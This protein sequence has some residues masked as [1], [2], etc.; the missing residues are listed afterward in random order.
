MTEPLKPR[1]PTPLNAFVGGVVEP[2]LAARGFSQASLIAH[3][4][5]I[6]GE[7]LA[8]IARPLTLKWPPRPPRADPDRPRAGATLILKVDGAFA[9]ELQQ[10]API[11]VNRINAHLGWRCVEKLAL[12]QGPLE[13]IR[14]RRRAKRAPPAE[15]IRRAAAA[16]EKIEDEGL[17]SSLTRLGAFALAKDEKD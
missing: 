17:R 2:T 5:E 14:P 1:G 8:A 3:W 16:T 11:V 7:H 15:A 9:L 10:A 12:R 4:P 6:V 13:E